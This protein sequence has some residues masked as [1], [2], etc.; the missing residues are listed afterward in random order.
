MQDY[1]L[2]QDCTEVIFSNKQDRVKET[3]LLQLER[4]KEICDVTRE[5]I[6]TKLFYS[7]I[8]STFSS[9]SFLC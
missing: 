8:E 7:H 2:L 5:E 9:S 3:F 6:P 1:L 4:Q